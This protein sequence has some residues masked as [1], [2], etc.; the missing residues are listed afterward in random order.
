[1]PTQTF[2]TRPEPHIGHRPT[3]PRLI[4]LRRLLV[5]GAAL[6]LTAAATHEMWQVLGLAR[7]T[8]LGAVMTFLFAVLML[9]LSLAFT[10]SIVGFVMVLRGRDEARLPVAAA[11]I[12]R[13]RT[14]LLVPVYNEDVTQVADAIAAMRA[15]LDACGASGYFDVFILSDSTT[16]GVAERERDAALHL[17]AMTGPAVH[18]RHRPRNTG[19][20]AGNIAEWVRRFGAAYPQFLIL[21]ADS[22]M[23]P[24]ALLALVETMRRHP[25]VGL[26]Q[27]LPRL[28]GGRTVFARL[29]EYANQVHGPVLA[30][31]QAWWQG[32][33]GNYWGHNALIRTAAFTQAG[34]PELPGRR[35]FG[36]SIMSHD[37][38]EAALI[39]RAGWAVHMLPLLPG[40]HEGSPPSLPDMAV[41]DRRWCQGNLQHAAVIGAAGLHPVSRLHMLTGIMSYLTAPI[42]L[43]FLLIG[44]AV[45]V[46]ARSLRPVYFPDTPVLFPQWPVVDAEKSFLVFLATVAILLTPKLLGLAALMLR[47]PAR[48]AAGR[49]Q[50]LLS[51]VIE[52]VISALISPITMVRQAKDCIAVLRGRDSG[53][54]AQA[55]D[56][57][58]V[59]W[60]DALRF[61]I[62]C[63][64]L[65]LALSVL[66]LAVDMRLALWLSP[67]LA[68][69]LLSPVLVAFTSSTRAAAALH[70]AG[71]LVTTEADAAS[72]GSPRQAVSVAAPRR[73]FGSMSVQAR[74]RPGMLAAPIRQA[75][76]PPRP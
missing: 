12:P 52:I 14:A 64:V 47:R 70:R 23:E 17:R 74:H 18:Y 15:G 63:L 37:F 25:D 7:W 45:S 41:R 67:V 50:L 49:H 11:V 1:M 9:P 26:L 8:T 75:G 31:G 32:A 38:V 29:Q 19:R 60:W 39:R 21:D 62:P 4:L 59:S 22:V 69:L 35:P 30:A 16:P 34:L 2:A 24:E 42:W 28:R 5:L 44:I 36:G 56:A 55:R 48:H 57:G 58:A 71:V 6:A 66:V 40:S 76:S 54:N 33:E 20:K 13:T 73:S 65:G 61:T 46:Q 43:A 10:S 53:W 72:G 27:T 51:G 3:A 68:G